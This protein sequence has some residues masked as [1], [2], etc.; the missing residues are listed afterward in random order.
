MNALDNQKILVAHRL[1]LVQHESDFINYNATLDDSL[2]MPAVGKFATIH[3]MDPII[4]DD[5]CIWTTDDIAYFANPTKPC[6][7]YWHE[8]GFADFYNKSLDRTN[9]IDVERM[10]SSF[11]AFDF[12]R[13]Y[14]GTG[15]VLTTGTEGRQICQISNKK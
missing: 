12:I 6:P 4:K 11:Q 14:H 7:S 13:L 1:Q 10:Y 15:I 2:V 8:C 9:V 5:E 3:T